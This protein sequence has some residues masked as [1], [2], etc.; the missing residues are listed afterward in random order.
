MACSFEKLLQYLDKRL[1]LDDKLRL[2]GHLDECETCREAMYQLAR[3]RDAEFFRGRPRTEEEKV[4][5]F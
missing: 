2:L 4:A 3:D 1:K 5:S